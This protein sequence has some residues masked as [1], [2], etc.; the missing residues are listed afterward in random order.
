MEFICVYIYIYIYILFYVIYFTFQIIV[1]NC[2][3]YNN[4]TCVKYNMHDLLCALYI[5]I[6]LFLLCIMHI[7]MYT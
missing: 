7:Y 5:H 1:L 6:S 3:K 4:V 2:I